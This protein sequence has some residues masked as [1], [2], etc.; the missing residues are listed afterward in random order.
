LKPRLSLLLPAGK[1]IKLYWICVD[2]L[3][4]SYSKILGQRKPFFT[5]FSFWGKKR[6]TKTSFVILNRERR[7]RELNLILEKLDWVSY[8]KNKK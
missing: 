3:S 5:F 8:K 4:I 6:K 1:K 2:S 7:P